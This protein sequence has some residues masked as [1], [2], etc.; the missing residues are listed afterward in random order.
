MQQIANAAFS[1]MFLE[2]ERFGRNRLESG[3]VAWSL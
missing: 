3:S 1:E 2:L